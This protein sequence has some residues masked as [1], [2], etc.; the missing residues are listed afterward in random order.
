ALFTPREKDCYQKIALLKAPDEIEIEQDKTSLIIVEPNPHPTYRSKLTK[1]WEEFY[2]QQDYKNRILFLTGSNST[3]QTVRNLSAQYRAIKAIIAEDGLELL[4]DTDPRRIEATQDREAIYAR[5]KMALK[6]A[7][8]LLLYPA[9]DGLKEAAFAFQLEAN[10]FDGE[11]EV[12]NT[13]L[14]KA[15]FTDEIEGKAFRQKCE[16]RLFGEQK[17]RNWSEVKKR[18]AANPHWPIHHPQ[19]LDILKKQAIAEGEWV[20]EGDF[21]NI[22]PPPPKATVSI[23]PF[24]QDPETGE[25]SLKIIPEYGNDVYYEEGE[26]IPNAH[27]KNIS[28]LYHF[29]TKALRINFLCVDREGKYESGD[30]VSW[31]NK[32]SVSHKFIH[33]LIELKAVPAGN[34]YYTLDGSDPKSRGIEYREPFRIEKGQKL[35][36]YCACHGKVSS[37]VK[38]VDVSFL[39]EGFKI[40]PQ[41]L[42]SWSPKFNHQRKSE[43]FQFLEMLKK[44]DGKVSDLTLDFCS[45][46]DV[47]AIDFAK[48]QGAL[49]C[50]SEAESILKSL[51]NAIQGT[52]LELKGLSFGTLQLQGVHLQDWCREKNI[53]PAKE[54]ISLCEG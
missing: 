19:G 17:R 47:Y 22:E 42:Y 31:K 33:H 52:E 18:A 28:E 4:T 45:S 1:R 8:H 40:D 24:Y 5:L 38:R 51:Q 39:H 6:E 23:N 46:D 43:A 7:F 25:A 15:K 44:C 36:A 10:E 32:I 11:T 37:E 41:Q 12:K 29:K 9:K 2:H 34:I 49:S 30:I 20:Q 35:L 54:D 53:D 26:G 14:N 13:L 3:L 48:N 27:S 50:Y 21:V 16:Q